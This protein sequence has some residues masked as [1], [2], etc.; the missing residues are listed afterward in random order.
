MWSA[1][2]LQLVV[3]LASSAQHF[4]F[5]LFL[6]CQPLF[7]EISDLGKIVNKPLGQGNLEAEKPKVPLS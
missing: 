5:M 2:T 7:E 6:E 3:S 1:T 4:L